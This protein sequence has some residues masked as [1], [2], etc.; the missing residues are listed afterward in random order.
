MKRV[1]YVVIAMAVV[2]LAYTG[3]YNYLKVGG[4]KI[5]EDKTGVITK[6]DDTYLH[7]KVLNKRLLNDYGIDLRVLVDN[8]IKSVD[9]FVKNELEYM[10]KHPRKKAKEFIFV[11]VSPKNGYIKI[12]STQAKYNTILKNK[13]IKDIK[14]FV[15]AIE[16]D[17][18]E[19]EI[20]HSNK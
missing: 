15:I 6:Q 3:V 9:T 20:Q 13:D 12:A 8:D 5:L 16:D 4:V 10:L 1:L 14:Q 17:L 19:Y 18:L 2:I 7:Y 11:L